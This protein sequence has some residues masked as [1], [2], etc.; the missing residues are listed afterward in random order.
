MTK[1]S[2]IQFEQK[3]RSILKNNSHPDEKTI[4]VEEG[5]K[6]TTQRQF[7]LLHY[8]E[9]IQKKTDGKNYK[10]ALEIGCGRGTIGL[11]LNKYLGM[12]V[13]LLDSSEDAINL[14]K[15]NFDLW[16]GKGNFFMENA[17][18]LPFQNESFDVVVSIGLLEHLSD[19]STVLSEQFRVLKKGGVMISL[20]IP[21]KK[22]VQ[23][24]ND[25]YRFIVGKY[26]K[27][28]LQKDYFRNEDMP[29]NYVEKTKASGFSDV[30]YFYVNPFPLFTPLG[31]RGE[32]ILTLFYRGIYFLRGLFMKYPFRGSR[33]FS[34]A[35]FLTGK[36]K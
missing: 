29:E 26:K 5:E 20:N 11:Y 16:K 15:Y 3:W 27:R 1:E 31:K 24:L 4:F 30:K 12:D 10:T 13:S 17:R 8:F 36:K 14:A 35:H 33:M 34:Q 18:K 7:N 32:H 2:N 21:K 23:F 9:F 22:S 25:V 28:T 6:P 19:Y